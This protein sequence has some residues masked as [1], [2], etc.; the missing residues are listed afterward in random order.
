M[1][2]MG[3]QDDGADIL[4]RPQTYGVV[5]FFHGYASPIVIGEL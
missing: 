1:Q 3:V 4:K 5:T 2:V